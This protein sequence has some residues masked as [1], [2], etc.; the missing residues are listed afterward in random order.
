MRVGD[1]TCLPI[2]L[3]LFRH[4]G[5]I[6]MFPTVKKRYLCLV[7]SQRKRNFEIKACHR[8]KAATGILTVVTFNWE[9]TVL[10]VGYH[11][12]FYILIPFNHCFLPV[13]FLSKALCKTVVAHSF[14]ADKARI[15]YRL[16]ESI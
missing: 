2:V 16:K 7:H 4:R 14:S 15:T 9:A 8:Y 5:F 12:I 6:K 11:R 3:N 1:L 10:P 13:N